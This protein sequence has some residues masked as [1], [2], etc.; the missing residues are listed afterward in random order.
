MKRYH[1]Q[2]TGR[3]V[4]HPTLSS[5]VLYA[6]SASRFGLVFLMGT[7]VELARSLL[8]D[9]AARGDKIERKVY[10]TKYGVTNNNL[11]F[12]NNRYFR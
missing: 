1:I 4:K 11:F 9:L 2:I 10:W 5:T 3:T 7:S 12:K 6:S 8:L